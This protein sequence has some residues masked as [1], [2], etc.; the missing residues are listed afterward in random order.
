MQIEYDS[1]TPPILRAIDRTPL[2]IWE[3]I[4]L[5]VPI[6]SPNSRLVLPLICRAWHGAGT[7]ALYASAHPSS[8]MSLHQTIRL[9][10]DLTRLIKELFFPG[11]LTAN[12]SHNPLPHITR[13][14]CV[15][16]SSSDV[17][18]HHEIRCVTTPKPK[19]YH[20]MITAFINIIEKCPFLEVLQTPFMSNVY[21]LPSNLTALHRLHTLSLIPDITGTAPFDLPPTAPTRAAWTTKFFLEGVYKLPNLQTLAI[22]STFDRFAR[23]PPVPD[24]DLPKLHTLFLEDV[25]SDI[26]RGELF[27]RLASRIKRL[28][29]WPLP[30]PDEHLDYEDVH[31]DSIIQ[32]DILSPGRKTLSVFHFINLQKLVIGEEVICRHF[33]INLR[34]PPSLLELHLSDSAADPCKY[35]NRPFAIASAI[36]AERHEIRCFPSLQVFH[37]R[38]KSA[39]WD[40]EHWR[41]V[42]ACNVW[43]VCSRSCRLSIP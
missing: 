9:K 15:R 41:A 21:P 8:V 25:G 34:L 4:F 11:Y 19:P 39:R 16:D 7:Y 31:F 24:G 18:V 29:I 6:S 2:E 23:L 33:F 38:W 42:T 32:L 35:V 28:V 27:Y 12:P 22:C 40:V 30:S 43:L 3:C 37:L 1:S 13:I 26:F 14:V 17:P 10:P 5:H 36:Y 20:Q